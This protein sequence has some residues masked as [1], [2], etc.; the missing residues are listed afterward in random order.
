MYY[1]INRD[2]VVEDLKK[3]HNYSE[4]NSSVLF[5]Q[6]SKIAFEIRR[7]STYEVP[8]Q[9]IINDRFYNID[10]DKIFSKLN[11]EEKKRLLNQMYYYTCLLYT[12]PSPR[13]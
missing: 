7:K 1:N 5:E 13:D 12:S 6:I 3:Y 9:K 2:K 10:F 4:K 11:L 8:Y